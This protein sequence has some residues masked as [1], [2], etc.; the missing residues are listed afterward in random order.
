[1]EAERGDTVPSD[2]VQNR[3]W[4]DAHMHDIDTEAF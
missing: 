1:M 4:L 3:R 2:E